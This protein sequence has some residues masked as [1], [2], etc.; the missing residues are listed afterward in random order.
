[1]NKDTL[2]DFI[3]EAESMR[4]TV[5]TWDSFANLQTALT[6]AKTAYT[7]SNNQTEIDMQT[8]ALSNALHDLAFQSRV[9]KFT[10]R[11]HDNLARERRIAQEA[12]NSLAVKVPVYPPWAPN[13]YA[14]LIEKLDQADKVLGNTDKNYNQAEVNAMSADLNAAI[15]V[16]RPGNLPEPED[17]S[18]LQALL[19]DARLVTNPTAT[20]REAIAHAQMIVDYVNDGSGT[21]DM[22]EAA[23]A[24]LKS[25]K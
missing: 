23:V 12:W 15:N 11:E 21:G 6:A 17:L 5:Y 14:R 3:H 20:L 7:S 1:V 2:G 10:L 9:N 4:E 19:R 8:I 18:E 22:I 16:M 13:G 25:A 24:R